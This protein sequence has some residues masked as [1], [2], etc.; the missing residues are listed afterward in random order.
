MHISLGLGPI[1]HSETYF[2][3]N[4]HSI[5]P[6]GMTRNATMVLPP[7]QH[8]E[9][10]LCNA[11]SSSFVPVNQWFPAFGRMWTTAP[12][13]GSMADHQVHSCRR[14]WWWCNDIIANGSRIGP[15]LYQWQ[16]EGT[17]QQTRRVSRILS[18]LT[19]QSSAPDTSHFRLFHGRA[20]N[21]VVVGIVSHSC[22]LCIYRFWPCTYFR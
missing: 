17:W 22:S 15:S 19:P 16:A 13:L 12:A 5:A 10:S 11:W 4:M 8:T 7:L 18:P 21:C 14:I 2:E 9:K 20:V 1:E 3:A 6:G